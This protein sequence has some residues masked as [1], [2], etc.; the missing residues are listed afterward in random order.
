[1]TDA[2]VRRIAALPAEQQ[3]EEVRKELMR[4]NPGFDGKMETKIEDGVVTEFWICTDHVTDIAP[5]RVFNGLRELDCPGTDKPSGVLADLTPL[6]GMHLAGLTKL[7]LGFSKVTDAGMIYFK[8][9]K[10]LRILSLGGTNVTDAG[11]VHFKGCNSLTE[12]N[13]WGTQVGDAGLI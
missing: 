13:L 5:I 6:E 2:D 8:D 10:Y 9:C 11:L 4:R 1:F 3:V 12:L 7:D